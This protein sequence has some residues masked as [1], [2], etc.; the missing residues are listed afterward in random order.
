M[1][2]VIEYRANEAMCRQRAAVEPEHS[3]RWLAQ[4]EMWSRQALDEIAA[5]FRE[6]SF[7]EPAGSSIRSRIPKSR[8]DGRATT[9]WIVR[10]V[11]LRT[12]KS[13]AFAAGFFIL[14][15]G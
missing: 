2:K 15:S 11:V 1:K 5:H 3:A 13:P 14:I 9:V 8:P 4:A 6:C 7:S 12:R 10:T